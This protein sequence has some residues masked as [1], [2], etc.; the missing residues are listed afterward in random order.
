MADKMAEN[1]LKLR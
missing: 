1:M